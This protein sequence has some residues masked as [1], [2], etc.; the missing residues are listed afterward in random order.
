[1]RFREFIF[2]YFG[3][4]PIGEIPKYKNEKNWLIKT[5]PPSSLSFSLYRFVN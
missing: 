1:M 5:L 2:K 3:I 4:S